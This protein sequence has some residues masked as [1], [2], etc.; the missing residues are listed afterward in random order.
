MGGMKA[1]DLTIQKSQMRN[2]H[3]H[4]RNDPPRM[5]FMHASCS[6]LII[7]HLRRMGLR[8]SLWASFWL[9]IR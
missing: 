4:P 9:V 6:S 7:N 1:M 2:M 8:L 3:S 5:R